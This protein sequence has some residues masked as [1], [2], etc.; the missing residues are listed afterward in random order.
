[1]NPVPT[2]PEDVSVV[3]KIVHLIFL[4]TITSQNLLTHAVVDF[5]NRVVPS[6]H[7]LYHDVTKL[8]KG[9]IVT[10]LWD[11]NQGYLARC[12]IAGTV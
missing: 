9:D 5:F 8:S 11:D 1:M 6:Q 2:K 10:I 7:I 4:L 12:I 3:V